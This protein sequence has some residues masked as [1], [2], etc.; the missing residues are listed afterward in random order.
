MNINTLLAQKGITKYR[1]AKISGV[2]QTTVIDIC[3][4]KAKI[5]K[6]S[7]ETIY[8]LAKAMG[9]SMESLIASAIEYRTA[10]PPK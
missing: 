9:V 2:P 10:F 3:S 6:C 1:L 5:E 4:G 7:G 8:K